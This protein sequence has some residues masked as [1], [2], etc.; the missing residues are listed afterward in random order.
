M[1]ITSV[2]SASHLRDRLTVPRI[3]HLCVFAPPV[4]RLVMEGLLAVG[5]QDEKH[6]Y[7]VPVPVVYGRLENVNGFI[8]IVGRPLG[9]RFVVGEDNDITVAR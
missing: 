6:G 4:V 1:E 9:E 7:P 2:V 8:E 5:C 3:N